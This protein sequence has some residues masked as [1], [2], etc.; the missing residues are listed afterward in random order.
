MKQTTKDLNGTMWYRAIKV[1]YAISVA[2][3]VVLV[4]LFDVAEEPRKMID[5]KKSIVVC[6]N[7]E[8]YSLED[9]GI[10]FIPAN[11]TYLGYQED[12]RLRLFCYSKESKF[13]PDMFKE[14][15]SYIDKEHVD[16][17]QAHIVLKNKL[18]EA[19]LDKNYAP[20]IATKYSGSWLLYIMRIILYSVIVVVFCDL[21]MRRPFYYIVTGKL[22]PNRKKKV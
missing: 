21:L 1:I 2:L 9:A 7:E 20:F 4:Y 3:L 11:R 18:S 12:A 14:I 13:L 22:F 17:I 10:S 5:L 15:E 6:D 8:S 19:G 16:H